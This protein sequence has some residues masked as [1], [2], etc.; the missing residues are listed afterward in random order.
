MT[1]YQKASAAKILTFNNCFN[2]LQ[3]SSLLLYKSKHF[4]AISQI[5]S[6]QLYIIFEIKVEKEPP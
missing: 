1:V 2:Q 5:K 6:T 4:L 3:N